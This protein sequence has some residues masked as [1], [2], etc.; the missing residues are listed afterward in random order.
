MS[1]NSDDINT[2]NYRIIMAIMGISTIICISAEKLETLI[3]SR[4]SILSEMDI[5]NHENRW[6]PR[7]IYIYINSN[8]Y[9]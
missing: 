6:G 9:I 1:G 4:T 5:S 8:A 3:I 7:A 2:D